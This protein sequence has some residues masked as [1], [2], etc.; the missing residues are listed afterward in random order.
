MVNYWCTSVQAEHDPRGP[1][2]PYQF[3]DRS[4]PL[5]IIKKWDGEELIHQLGFPS[6]GGDKAVARWV[7]KAVKDN[8]PVTPPKAL[9]PLLKGMLK[10]NDLIAKEKH[11]DAWKELTKVVKLGEDERKFPDGLPTV[12]KEAQVLV[13]KILEDANEAIE[14]A[15]GHEDAAACLKAL[16]KLASTYRNVP[17]LKKRIGDEIKA[18]K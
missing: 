16:R 10:A 7:E 5:F 15:L 9:K 1:D 3:K 14:A 4:V 6:S 11:G 2:G 17:D 8:G 12:A 18:R 13:A